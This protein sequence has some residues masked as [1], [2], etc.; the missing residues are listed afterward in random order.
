M[1]RGEEWHW[2]LR[3]KSDPGQLIGL[4]GL[5][6]TENNNRGYWLGLP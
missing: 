2:S 5:M 4:L 6:K 1:E 3:L